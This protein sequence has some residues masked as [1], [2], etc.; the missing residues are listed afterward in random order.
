MNEVPLDYEEAL[1][2]IRELA[3]KGPLKTNSSGPK[4]IS[5]AFARAMGFPDESSVVIG[6]YRLFTTRSGVA[7]RMSLFSKVSDWSK[8]TFKSSTELLEHFGTEKAG[9]L[10]LNCTM[11]YGIENSHGLALAL[12]ADNREIHSV[13]NRLP[14]NPVEV[15]DVAAVESKILTKFF[16]FGIVHCDSTSINGIEYARLLKVTFYSSPK[17]DFVLRLVKSGALTIDH[18]AGETPSGRAHEKG[19]IF[20]LDRLALA[21]VFSSSSTHNL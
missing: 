16:K 1:A 20:K 11:R 19:P 2:R 13:S 12:S 15:W 6:G 4:A 9:R 3:R 17:N 10:S 18:L 14:Q 7:S 5:N 8:A 21:R